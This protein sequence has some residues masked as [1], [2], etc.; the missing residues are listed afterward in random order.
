MKSFN[1]AQDV[2]CHPESIPMREKLSAQGDLASK[3]DFHSLFTIQSWEKRMIE[4][5][6][7]TVSIRGRI[8]A[9]LILRYGEVVYYVRN[10]KHEQNS[11]R[12]SENIPSLWMHFISTWCQ[13]RI[14][15]SKLKFHFEWIRPSH[16]AGQWMGLTNERPAYRSRDRSRPISSQGLI[17]ISASPGNNNWHRVIKLIKQRRR[18]MYLY[19]YWRLPVRP[20]LVSL[21]FMKTP[22]LF[23]FK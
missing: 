15:N 21:L 11:W 9:K 2:Q 14:S 23:P 3:N 18:C 8:H 16:R 5:F 10:L 12:N 6:Y 22:L 13:M 20:W 4:F 17:R 7:W 19:K 1:P